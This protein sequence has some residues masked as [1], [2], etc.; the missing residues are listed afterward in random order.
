MA[1]GNTGAQG[2]PPGEADDGG[3]LFI[4]SPDA[5]DACAAMAGH[6]DEEPVVPAHDSCRCQV[7]SLPGGIATDEIRNVQSLP[8]GTW[9]VT[10]MQGPYST[11]DR[12]QPTTVELDVSAFESSSID[13][14][15]EDYAEISSGVSDG[16][17]IPGR[18]T[19]MLNLTLTIEGT[20]YLGE[21]W[22]VRATP[23][24]VAGTRYA[25]TFVGSVGAYVQT[26]ANIDVEV[27]TQRG[28]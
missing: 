13:Q 27:A 10:S 23:D 9:T 15:M 1:D 5:C 12:D 2:V 19:A 4:P 22:R 17:E 28:G 26:V 14:G 11:R 6:H 7:Q 8:V 20:L 3:W 25:E 21:K 16:V 18:C 24:P